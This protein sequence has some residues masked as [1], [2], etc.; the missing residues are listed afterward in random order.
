[1]D[2]GVEKAMRPYY[3]RVFGNPS[4]VHWFGQEASAAVFRAREAI[5]RAIGADYQEIIFTGSAT[6]ANNIALRG[7]VRAADFGQLSFGNSVAVLQRHGALRSRFDAP[8][9]VSETKPSEL[10]DV[11]HNNMPSSRPYRIIISCIEHESVLETARDLERDGLVEVVYVPVNREGII[12]VKKFTASLDERTI[13]VSIQY[14]NSQIGVIQPIKEIGEIIKNHKLKTKNLYPLFHTDAVQAFQYM[15]CR[16]D[17]MGVDMLTLSA[18]KIYGPKGIGALYVRNLKTNPSPLATFITGGGQEHGIRSG[19][20]NVPAIVGFGEAVARAE[21]MRGKET[22]RIQTLRDYFWRG[23]QKIARDAEINGSVEKRLPNNLNIYFQ[24]V[25]AQDMCIELD[26]Q[27][28]AV[29]PGSACSS[30]AAQPSYV[31]KALGFSGDRPG[32]SIR[33]SF[34]R[35]TVKSDIDAALSVLRRRFA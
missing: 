28:I 9:I 22:K 23:L 12:D 8:I 6:E 2:A 26:L 3:A 16:I 1:M 5:A 13:L 19:T 15:P 17:D 14:A 4:S 10:R 25:P 29:S 27:G 32:S 33:F 7:V 34:G 11:P 24:G 30:R 21:R 31:I 20:E 35:P 18:H